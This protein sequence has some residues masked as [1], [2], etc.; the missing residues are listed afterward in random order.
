MRADIKIKF[1]EVSGQ[2]VNKKMNDSKRFQKSTEKTITE[3]C[4]QIHRYFEDFN[5]KTD[6]S[7]KLAN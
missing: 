4:K 6:V 1:L 2:K 5:I 3:L 7:F